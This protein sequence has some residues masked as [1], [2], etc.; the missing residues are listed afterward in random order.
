FVERGWCTEEKKIFRPVPPL[1]IARKWQGKHRRNMV[2]DYD[3]AM[4]LI[5]ACV[6]ESGINASDT[7]RNDN[8]RPHRALDGLLE[9][10]ARRAAASE[11]RSAA[12]RARII[13][14]TFE[15]SQKGPA[16]LSFLDEG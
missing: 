10:H 3:Q 4:F 14:Q 9:W 16:Q 12:A 15:R 7:L 5:G 13:L 2:S 6:D 8:F 1:E 11:V